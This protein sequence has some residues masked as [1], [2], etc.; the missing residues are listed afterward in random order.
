MCLGWGWYLQVDFQ[1]FLFGL[2]LLFLYRRSRMATLLLSLACIIAS[3]TFNITFTYNHQ[4]R[5]F[6]DLSAF[7]NFGDFML[8]LYMKP[9]GRCTPYLMGLILGI[10]YMEHRI[11][12]KNK[13]SLHGNLIIGKM[14]RWFSERKAR[15]AVE[16][17]GIGLMSFVA[18]IPRCQQTGDCRWSQTMHSLYWGLSKPIFLLGMTMTILPSMLGH[19][20]S[21]F[22][23][24]L[25]PKIFT[26]I[27][28]TSFCTY[29]VHLMVLDYFILS[30]NYNLYYNITDVFITYLGLLVQSLIFGFLTT[31]FIELPFAKLQKY[32]VGRLKA[33][34][35]AK[36]IKEK[37]QMSESLLSS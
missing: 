35:K 19:F 9:W 24:I 6:T 8:D 27:A 14:E 26:F 16:W 32:A 12:K 31:M 23:L 20:H 11:A 10:F 28:R 21:F 25:T 30:R 3:T 5:I 1:L 2:L 36:E 34:A 4:I 37:P 15:L 18:F 13:D 17:I 29:L 7:V 33:K 22:N